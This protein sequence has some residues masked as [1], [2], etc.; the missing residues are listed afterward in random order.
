MA[1]GWSGCRPSERPWCE[2]ARTCASPAAWRGAHLL[3][4]GVTN[5][6][7]ARLAER[8]GMEAVFITGAGVANTNFGFPDHGMT[9]LGEI[10]EVSRRVVAAIDIPVIADADLGYGGHLNVMRTVRELE[11][12]GVAALIIED[13][14]EPKRCGHFDGKSVS[15]RLGVVERLMRRSPRPHRPGHGRVRPHR[16]DRSR[17]TRR[18]PRARSCTWRRAPTRSLWRRRSIEEMSAIAAAVE[19][20]C[21]INLV[22]GSATPIARSRRSSGWASRSRCMPTLRCGWR[23]EASKNSRSP[24]RR[25]LR[26][27]HRPDVHLGAAP[28]PGSV[29]PLGRH[30][31]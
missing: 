4:P 8:A 27:S 28:G 2:R 22:E 13:Q 3:V 7:C 14:E 1:A 29:R 15:V 11:Q 9:T 24:S 10:V 16:R 31:S 12:A 21:L 17:R 23:C 6:R 5:A 18:R 20:P 26:R 25:R 19:V 30:R